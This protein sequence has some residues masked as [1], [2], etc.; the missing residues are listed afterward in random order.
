M[1]YPR[2]RAAL[3]RG[4]AAFSDEY[5]T[6]ERTAWWRSASLCRLAALYA[7]R[8]RWRHLYPELL[9]RAMNGLER[10]ETS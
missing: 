9:E 5:D 10:R 3:E 6:G 1:Q 4:C 7:L 8:P 2:L